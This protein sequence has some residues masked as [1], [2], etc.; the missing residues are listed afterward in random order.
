[1]HLETAIELSDRETAFVGGPAAGQRPTRVARPAGFS[2]ANALSLSG[3]P[4][5]RGSLLAVARDAHAIPS[6]FEGQR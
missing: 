6:E 1:M 2:A 3:K 4:D 5:L